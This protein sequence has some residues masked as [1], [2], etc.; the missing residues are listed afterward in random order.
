MKKGITLV[1]SAFLMPLA[2]SLVLA[3]CSSNKST[4]TGSSASPKNT[5]AV[6]TQAPKLKPAEVSIYYPGSPQK[7]VA[8]VE[9]EMNKILK[10]KINATVKINAVDWSNWTQKINLMSASNEPFDLVFTASWDNF[11]GNIAKGAFVDMLPLMD[12]YGQDIKKSINPL[13][14][15]GNTLNGKLYALPTQKEFASQQGMFLLKDLVD[16]YNI[17]IKSINKL[18]DLEP[19]LQ[20]IKDKEPDVIPMWG[21]SNWKQVLPYESIGN[22]KVPGALVKGGDLKVVNQ[23]EQADIKQYYELMYSW[24]KKGFFQKDAATNTDGTPSAKAGKVFAQW[25]QLKPGADGEYNTTHDRKVVQVELEKTPFTTTGDLNN[26]MLAISRTSNDPERAMMVLNLLHSDAKLLNL[27][28]NGVEG[29]QYVKV[30]GKD[31]VIKLPDGVKAGD[32]GYT[33]GANWM[34]GNQFL[35][36]LWDN[37]DPQKWQKYDTFNKAATATKALGFTFDSSNTKNEEAAI[38]SIYDSYREGLGAGVLD[39]AKALPEMNDKLKKAGVDKV[40]AEMQK[41]LDEFMKNKK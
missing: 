11:S 3:G 16:K 17:D 23:Y 1:K 18:S 19:I 33:P 14:I 9:G 28:V 41:Q 7:D 34:F 12:K 20:T 35:N 31:N 8:L 26:S 40:I 21:T 32:T 37:E 30:A 39:P 22:A 29:K 24:N 5:D 38:V 4:D 27:L 10:E 13:F 36:Y 15:S 25:S 6:S 2:L